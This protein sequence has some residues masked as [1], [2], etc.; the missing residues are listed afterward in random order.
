MGEDLRAE[1]R[2]AVRTPMQ[3][4]A[5]EGGGFSTAAAD[6]L[7]GAV[8]EGAYG[9][10]HVN[11]QDQRRDPGSLLGFVKHLV[12]RYRECPELGWGAFAVL[13]QPHRG[14]LAHSVTWEDACLVALHNLSAEPCTVPLQVPGAQ[15]GDA[16]VDLLSAYAAVAGP[17]GRVDV[18]LGRYGHRWLRTSRPGDRRLV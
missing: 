17:D 8:V 10:D 6:R 11:V 12:R 3:W 18:E 15:E 2:L 7:P 4:T 9:P 14:V 1:G 13:D 16:L 5:G